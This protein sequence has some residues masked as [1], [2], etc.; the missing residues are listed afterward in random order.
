M[1]GKRSFLICMQFCLH[2]LPTS[3]QQPGHFAFYEYDPNIPLRRQQT[4]QVT[5]DGLPG[6]LWGNI[7]GQNPYCGLNPGENYAFPANHLNPEYT[8]QGFV[9]YYIK[10]RE[11]RPGPHA[12]TAKARYQFTASRWPLVPFDAD[13][14]VITNHLADPPMRTH[15]QF[16]DLYE[17]FRSIYCEDS[18][19]QVISLYGF[20]N[21]GRRTNWHQCGV[22]E[23]LVRLCMSDG[24]V[25]A[26]TRLRNTATRINAVFR[27]QVNVH[28]FITLSLLILYYIAFYCIIKICKI[29]V[30]KPSKRGKRRIRCSWTSTRALR[31]IFWSRNVEKQ[32]TDVT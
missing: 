31:T 21:A 26:G 19:M 6:G 17:P 13:T 14:N 10:K 27:R 16:R 8:N 15:W 24:E 3:L 11:V 12:P 20:P 5:V 1:F 23:K 30:G 7:V 2:Q 22:I 28:H 32:S 9:V 4:V 29:G 18:A 25:N